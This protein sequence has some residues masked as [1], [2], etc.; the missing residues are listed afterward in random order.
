MRVIID[1]LADLG[2]MILHGFGVTIG[3]QKTSAFALLRQ[4]A[5]KMPSSTWM[6]PAGRRKAMDWASP[7]TSSEGVSPGLSSP[8]TEELAAGQCPIQPAM[9]SMMNTRYSAP[10]RRCFRAS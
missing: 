2:K 6:T 9:P 10:L 1:G 7:G 5:P 8:R 3:Q 4:N